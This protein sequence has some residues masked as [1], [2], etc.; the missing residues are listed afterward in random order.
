MVEKYSKQEISMT[1]AAILPGYIPENYIATTVGTSN[2]TKV[3][4]FRGETVASIF[5]YLPFFYPED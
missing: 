3:L 1:Q 2:P 5:R 4:M